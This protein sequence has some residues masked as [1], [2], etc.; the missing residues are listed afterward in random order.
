[1]R[2]TFFLLHTTTTTKKKEETN[3]FT[4]QLYDDVK[5]E[6]GTTSLIVIEI[7]PTT[8]CRRNEIRRCTMAF[9]GFNL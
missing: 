6:T 5:T 1:M 3:R 9:G 2:A 7:E 8:E 4:Q